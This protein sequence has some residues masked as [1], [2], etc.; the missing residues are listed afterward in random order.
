MRVIGGAADLLSDLRKTIK[1]IGEITDKVVEDYK[2]LSKV[3]EL[4]T[5]TLSG[6]ND[7]V[8]T[9]LVSFGSVIGMF[10]GF[11]NKNKSQEDKN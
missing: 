9:P 7:K 6:I 1:N 10:S 5:N 3:I 2:A 4:I 8:L 11:F